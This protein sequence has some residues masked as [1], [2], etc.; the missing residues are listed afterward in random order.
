MDRRIVVQSLRLVNVS[1]PCEKSLRNNSTAGPDPLRP[2]Q[3][4]Q[5][6]L[7]SEAALLESL[8]SFG[9]HVDID[10]ARRHLERAGFQVSNQSSE[11]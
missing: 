7:E 1:W 6:K 9:E 8:I 5:A 2:R 11:N 3:P 4:S 10:S